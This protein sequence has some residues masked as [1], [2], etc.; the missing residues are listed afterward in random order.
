M[1]HLVYLAAALDYEIP[2]DR[3][4]TTTARKA[5]CAEFTSNCAL[6]YFDC[7][8]VYDESNIVLNVLVYAAA[9]IREYCEYAEY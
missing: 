9:G 2:A 1:T 7:S 3:E 8:V 6:K 5:D 4:G